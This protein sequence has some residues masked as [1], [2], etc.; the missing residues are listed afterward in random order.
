MR[1]A[2]FKN[3]MDLVADKRHFEEVMQYDAFY[4]MDLTQRQLDKLGRFLIDRY[5]YPETDKGVRLPNGL[6]I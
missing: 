6:E 2:E 3:Y 1:A 5:H 4:F